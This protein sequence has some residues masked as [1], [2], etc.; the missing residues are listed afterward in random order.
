[1]LFIPIYGWLMSHGYISLPPKH[2]LAHHSS[3]SPVYFTLGLLFGTYVL[4][5]PGIWVYSLQMPEV[6]GITSTAVVTSTHVVTSI[7]TM[8]EFM[9]TTATALASVAP[10]CVV[11]PQQVTGLSVVLKA[12]LT[13]V[14]LIVGTGYNIVSL[15]LQNITPFNIHILYMTVGLAV[16]IS[17]VSFGVSTNLIS[18]DITGT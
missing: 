10:S 8:T 7:T 4:A 12:V 3:I 15:A 14:S 6:V 18:S 1:M 9:T 11:C 13:A 17:T 2:Y 5:Q 16:T